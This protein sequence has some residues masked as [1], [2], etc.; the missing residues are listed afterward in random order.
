MAK[1]AVKA[2]NGRR[3]NLTTVAVQ[4]NILSQTIEAAFLTAR[5]VKKSRI[6]AP[7]EI[8]DTD[9]IVPRHLKKKP[10]GKPVTKRRR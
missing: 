5:A 9:S 8:F 7:N 6:E 2:S 1:N 4:Q 3:I 10:E